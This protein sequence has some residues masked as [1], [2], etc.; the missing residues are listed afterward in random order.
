VMFWWGLCLFGFAARPMGA[1]QAIG[2]ILIT[3]LFIGVSVPMM[4]RRMLARHPGYAAVMERRLS[5]LP[6]PRRRA[7]GEARAV[8]VA[9]ADDATGGEEGDRA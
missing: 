9:Q 6:W 3:G 7:A 8:T 5:L 4:D 2:A 1:W